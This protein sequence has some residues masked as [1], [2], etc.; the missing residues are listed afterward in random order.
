MPL[1]TATPSMRARSAVPDALVPAV[2]RTRIWAKRRKP[3]AQERARREMEFLIGAA[4]P[5]DVDRAAQAYLERDVWR[6]EMRYHPDLLTHMAVENVGALQRARSLG[7]GV[8]LSFLHHGHYE[9]S[10]AS[11]SRADQPFTMIVSPDMLAPD[12]PAFLRQHVITGTA[13]GAHPVTSAIGAKAMVGLLQGGEV[14]GIATDVPGR[15][16]LSFLG[17]ERLGSSGAARLAMGANSPVVMLFARR[18][19]DGTLWL[20]LSD[21]VEPGDFTSPDELLAHL[22]TAQEPA[23][24]AWPEG[25]HQPTLR[26]GRVEAAGDD[27]SA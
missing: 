8:V 22:I 16:R 10:T 20:E 11:V 2:V 9:G 4:R 25:Y 17:Q 19:S 14:L 27:G 5:D 13:T 1:Q 21:P 6:S 7:R 15:T 12:A 26:W 18:A 3:A 23:V 24:L